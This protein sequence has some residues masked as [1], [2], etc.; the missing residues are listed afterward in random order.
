MKNLTKTEVRE[1]FFATH[2]QF[3]DEKKRGKTHN[4]YST[5]CRT[6]FSIFIDTL[7]RNEEISDKQADSL[8]LG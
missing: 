1:L 8:I 3:K 5:D 4:E 6:S 2:P 7:H